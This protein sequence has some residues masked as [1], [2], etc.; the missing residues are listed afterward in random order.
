MKVKDLP[1]FGNVVLYKKISSQSNPD[2]Y[3]HDDVYSG[4]S[5]CIPPRYLSAEVVFVAVRYNCFD[6]QIKEC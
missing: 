2:G 6:I 3:S 1:L 5:C 4:S